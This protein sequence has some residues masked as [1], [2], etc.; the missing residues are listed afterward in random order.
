MAWHGSG[1]GNARGLCVSTRPWKRKAL[2]CGENGW[3]NG[4]L[5]GAIRAEGR[6]E[7]GGTLSALVVGNSRTL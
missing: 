3:R 1:A 2:Q 5:A 6:N 4:R 7:P